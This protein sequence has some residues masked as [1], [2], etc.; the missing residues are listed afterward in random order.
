MIRT[1][2]I[3]GTA[4][5]TRGSRIPNPDAS[6]ADKYRAAYD[7]EIAYL[8]GQLARLFDGLKASGLYDRCVIVLT[9]DHGEEFHEHG[10]WW[11]GTTLYD[12]QITVP[13]IVKPPR[14]G[15]TGVVND[16]IVSS[17][18]VA[19]TILSLA[20]VPAPDTMIG[21]AL[22]LTAGA[23]G[24]RDHS[25]AEQDLEGNILQ[26]FRS[27]DWKLIQANPGN[28][29]GLP[30]RQL[31]AIAKDPHEQNDLAASRARRGRDP[32][33]ADECGA[34]RAPRRWRCAA[35]RRRSTARPR[36]ACARSATC[37][38]RAVIAIIGLDGAT[39]E[40]AEPLHGGRRH[41][42]APRRSSQ[43]GG[44]GCCARRCRR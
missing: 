23:P 26:A 9:A 1:S 31:F 25:F 14:G 37:T 5:R 38:E 42:G 41:A 3:R 33:G 16:A 39:W 22:G 27:E 2:S 10:G 15:Q 44:P 17:L 21:K 19:P 6:L 7:G 34:R 20:G 4:R 11:H 28:P 32:R 30:P 40:L 29:R 24:P 12:E 43:P 35:A 18:D 8:D 13:L 36:S